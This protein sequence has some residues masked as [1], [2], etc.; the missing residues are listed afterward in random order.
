[1]CVCQSL[2]C[3]QP[4]ATPWTVAHQAPL[5]MGFFRQGYWNGLPFPSPED[6][7]DPG[8]EPRS[9]ALHA[10]SLPLSYLGNVKLLGK[11]HALDTGPFGYWPQLV[12]MHIPGIIT[13]NLI[14]TYS[15]TQKSTRII[16]LRCLFFMILNSLLCLTI[17][18]WGSFFFFS[19]S[20][21]NHLLHFLVPPLPFCSSSSEVSEKL[22]HGLYSSAIF[23]SK[24]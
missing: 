23:L 17:C 2:S 14:L 4:F 13:M 3:V 18:F 15:H 20:K 24:I 9:P 21:K 12:K 16:N 1:M 7:S 8:I 19:Y 5:P 11:P 6:P 22:S 10:D